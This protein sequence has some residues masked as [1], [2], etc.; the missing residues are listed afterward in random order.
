MPRKKKTQHP[1]K[2]RSPDGLHIAS[3]SIVDPAAYVE[4]VTI[5]AVADST[6]FDDHPGTLMRE[7]PASPRELRMCDYPLGTRVIVRRMSDGS[8]V[9]KLIPPHWYHAAPEASLN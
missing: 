9:R 2:P 4:S 7:R 5:D 8:Q 3:G 6:W 1:R